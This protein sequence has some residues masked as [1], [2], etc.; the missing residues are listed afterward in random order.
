MGRVK[1]NLWIEIEC[2]D[3]TCESV[4]KSRIFKKL[5]WLVNNN[6][7][8]VLNS[9]LSHFVIITH[10]SCYYTCKFVL[11]DSLNYAKYPLTWVLAEAFRCRV[12][13]FQLFVVPVKLAAMKLVFWFMVV[14]IAEMLACLVCVI[15]RVWVLECNRPF[16][17]LVHQDCRALKMVHMMIKSFC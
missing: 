1:F 4:G 8:N 13:H 12:H 3:K 2:G 9:I 11:L 6:Y 14:G 16:S 17:M 7:S 5:L 15:V 10:L